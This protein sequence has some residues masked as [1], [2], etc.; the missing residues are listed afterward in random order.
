MLDCWT[1]GQAVLRHVIDAS[2]DC[3]EI[4]RVPFLEPILE[5]VAK[6]WDVA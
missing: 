4:L 6:H 2:A 3:E 5:E 1:T